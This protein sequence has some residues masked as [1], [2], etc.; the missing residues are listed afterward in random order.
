MPYERQ[1]AEIIAGKH[2]NGWP[3]DTAEYVVRDKPGILH[4]ADAGHKGHEG[5]NDG[6]E[7][8]QDNGLSPVLFIEFMRP[9]Q[10]LF[11][12]K[13]HILLEKNFRADVM[14]YPVID[15]VACNGCCGEDDSYELY[16]KDPDG[17]ECPG[18]EEQGI[19]RQKGSD[20]EAGF[21]KDNHKKD[22]VR[23]ASEAFY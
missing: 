23:P 5:A 10:V 2:K 20:H 8:G 19:P 16:V 3:G 22:Q 15:I 9:V 18:C 17:S 6:D 14:P 12:K 4:P 21:A 13:A 7:T 11:V 1:V